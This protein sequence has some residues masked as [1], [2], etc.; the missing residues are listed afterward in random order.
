MMEMRYRDV[1]RKCVSPR[2]YLICVSQLPTMAFGTGSTMKYQDV[3]GYVSQ[4]MLIENGFFHID[5]AQ[6]MLQLPQ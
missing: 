5:T 1:S 6:C 4:A 2:Q 3:T